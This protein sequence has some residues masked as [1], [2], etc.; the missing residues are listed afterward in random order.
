MSL[1]I[2]ALTK[3]YGSQKAVDNIS[4]EVRKGEV[5][6]FIGP[7]GSGKSTTMKCICGIL[8]PDS[9]TLEVSGINVQKDAMSVKKMIGYLPE[10]NPLYQDMYVREY[11]G[12]IADYYPGAN[13]GS[14]HVNEIIDKT[15][16]T[17]ESNKKIGQLSK[18]YRQRVGLA[19]AMIHNPEVL[20]L[21][22]PTTGLDPNQIIEIR[23]L[24]SG[25]SKDKTVLL[26]THI[27][28]EV[29]AICDRVLIINNGKII[30]DG[31]PEVIRQS[32]DQNNQTIFIEFN[33]EVSTGLLLKI[34][35]INDVRKLTTTTYLLAGN[36][37]EDLRE[38]IFN[39][40]LK[41]ELKLLTIQ[42]KE[43]TLED[44]FRKLTSKI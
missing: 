23:N 15:G 5:V 7:N 9:G 18:G 22:E 26:S 21:D 3:S 10:N 41:N 36:D 24:I 19:Q 39:F 2:N 27:L 11:L 32:S 20:I 8:P 42:K 4:F 14:K 13:K 17:P 29:E 25:L 38:R 35:G 40:A 1:K 12:H 33:S 31:T 44:S 6:G 28:Q 16:L 34:D 30:A 37:K 43:D